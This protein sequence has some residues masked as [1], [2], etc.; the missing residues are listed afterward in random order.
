M[1]TPSRRIPLLL[2]TP[3]LVLL[4]V[5]LA[6]PLLLLLRVSLY[7]PAHG[8]GFYVPATWTLHNYDELL[9][10][11]HFRN[12]LGFTMAFG[13]GVTALTLLLGYPLALFIDGLPPRRK[14]LA[15][16]A[17]LLPKLA[18]VL[19]VVNGLQIML[20]NS[21]PVNGL[22]LLLRVAAEPV[23]LYRNLLGAVVGEVY[24]V[25]P[26][27][28]L[29]LVAGLGRIDPTLTA[30]ARGL[31]ATP[32]LA[33]RTVTWPLSGSALVVAGE[34]TLI[35]ALGA[36]IGPVLLGSPQE[37]TLAVE[38]QHQALELNHWPRGAA[39]GVILLALVGV[40]VGLAAWLGHHLSPLSPRGRGV[41]GEGEGPG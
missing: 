5:G 36:L 15:L 34:L 29:I 2:A 39:T 12:I 35:W 27:A 11:N 38:V 3:A 13:L 14:A 24:L 33:F 16:A 19:A 10:D 7:E 31:G 21:G 6:G 23:M 37:T 20:S 40:C 25:L 9:G 17:V 32:W 18:S 22:L 4:L 41:G 28:V 30:A 8:R 26:Y 1:K